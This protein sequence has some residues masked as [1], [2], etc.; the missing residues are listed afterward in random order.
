MTITRCG[1]LGILLESSNYA[2]SNDVIEKS[3]FLTSLSALSTQ[4]HIKTRQLSTRAKRDLTI[5]LE[6]EADDDIPP[7]TTFT[8]NPHLFLFVLIFGSW[9]IHS[10][11]IT[12]RSQINKYDRCDGF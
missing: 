12:E 10:S 8:P 4:S 2:L 5:F 11:S 6:P 7:L 1:M 9:E 3:H